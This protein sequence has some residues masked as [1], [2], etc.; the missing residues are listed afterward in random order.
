M[1]TIQQSEEIVKK[2]KKIM[3]YRFLDP[4][5]LNF[6]LDKSEI[7]LFE[8]GEAIIRQGEVNQS[9]Y[10]IIEGNVHVTVSNENNPDSYICAIGNGE[11]FG[12]AG[13]FLKVPRTAN[14]VSSSKTLVAMVPR[15]GILRMIREFPENGNKVLMMIIFSLLRKLKESNQELAF[16]RRDDSQQ[17]DIDA[18]VQDLLGN[19]P[20]GRSSV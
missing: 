12:E 13:M 8:E 6:L 18:L 7:L 19:L 2:A 15:K 4:D 10:S 11:V 3:P 5:P 20:T 14:V 17:D 1:K 9:F 16:E